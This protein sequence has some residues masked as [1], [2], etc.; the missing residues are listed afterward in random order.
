MPKKNGK[1]RNSQISFQKNFY[2]D[3]TMERLLYAAIVRSPVSEGIVKS[4]THPDLPEEYTLVT[5]RDIPG[6]NLIDTPHGKIPIFCEGNISYEGQPLALLTGPDETDLKRILQELVIT[7]DTNSIEDYLPTEDDITAENFENPDRKITKKI[8]K[9]QNEEIENIREIREDFFSDTIAKRNL[10]WGKCFEKKDGQEEEAG[11]ESVFKECDYTVENTWTYALKTPEYSEPTGAICSWKQNVLTVIAPTLWINGLRHMLS[12]VLSID[13]DSINIKKTIATNRGTNTIWFNSIISCQVAAASLKTGHPVKLV[14]TRDEQENFLDTIQPISITHKSAVKAD[15]TITAM[16]ININV[17][18]G[19]A[20]PLA[21]EILDRLVIASC[22]IYNPQNILVEAKAYYSSR[23]SSSVDYK[24]IDSAA[25]FAVENQINEIAKACNLTPLEI[26]L[27][28]IT[29][30]DSKKSKI[31]FKKLFDF[32]LEKE[33]ETIEAAVKMSDYNRKYASFH[34]DSKNWALDSNP[35]EY[36]SVFSPPMRG[37]GF[38]CGFQGSEYSAS[39]LNGTKQTLEV[40]L[41]SENSIIIH[42]PPVSP[43]IYEIW[44]KTV[45]EILEKPGINV[46]ID[47]DFKTGEEPPLP[48]NVSSNINIMTELLKK[49]CASIKKRKTSDKLPYSVKKKIFSTKNEWNSE[50]FTGKPFYAASFA[51]A[52]IELELNSCTYSEE[53]KSMH[54]IIN[55]GKILN[56]QAAISSIRL[57]VQKILNSL[58]ENESRNCK[59]IKISFIQSDRPPAAIGE[60]IY[61]ILPAAFTQALS[62]AMNC[63]LNSLPLET[64]TL[65]NTL[66]KQKKLIK[67]IKAEQMLQEEQKDEDSTDIKQQ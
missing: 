48:E 8:L 49:C 56:K 35:K 45:S 65:F 54:F 27:K 57:Q 31:K 51:A 19:F 42:T 58:T 64:D 53:I 14:Y 33:K 59:N 43:S 23:P 44:K 29:E 62:Q 22:G 34:L 12:Q 5:S 41:E 46:K 28:N 25:F 11:I 2:S 50:E 20:N 67:K 38:A 40:T 63:V 26:R 36:V 6:T 60:I 7:V 39:I 15:G 32:D 37:I 18:A 13:E 30:K 9:Q 10:S 61:Q 17:D 1:N 66:E 16:K 52:V 47:S 24:Q 55:G 4:I 3:I 21:Q